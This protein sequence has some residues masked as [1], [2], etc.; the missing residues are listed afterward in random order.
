MACGERA[1]PSLVSGSL[2]A[3]A[4]ASPLAT[5]RLPTDTWVRS[6]AHQHAFDFVAQLLNGERLGNHERKKLSDGDVLKIAAIS[7]KVEIS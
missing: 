4:G 5:T 3:P 2:R 1:G 6:A 7:F